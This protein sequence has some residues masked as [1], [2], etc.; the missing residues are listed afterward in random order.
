MDKLQQDLQRTQTQAA[1]LE[2]TDVKQL[3]LL[4]EVSDRS[5]RCLE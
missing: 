5:Y 3:I 1:T 2:K 4:G